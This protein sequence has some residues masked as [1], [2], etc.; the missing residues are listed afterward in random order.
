MSSSK[1]LLK[2]YFGDAFFR[3]GQEELIDALLAGR[4]MLGVMSTGE[5]PC[6]IRCLP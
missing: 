2:Q 3:E 1:H 4:D 5:N 6:A